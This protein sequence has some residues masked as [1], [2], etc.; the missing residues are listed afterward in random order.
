M[1]ELTQGNLITLLDEAGKEVEF[2]LLMSFDY[3]GKR[4]IA[5]LPTESVEGVGEDEVVLLE[6]KKDGGEDVFCSIDNPVLLSE[7]FDVFSELF[8]DELDGDDESDTDE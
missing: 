5:L 8:E 2:D 1:E 3:E 4:Y 6:V 7:V